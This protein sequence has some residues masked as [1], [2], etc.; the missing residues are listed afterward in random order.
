MSIFK[1]TTKKI[2]IKFIY[3][4]VNVAQ[5]TFITTYQNVKQNHEE[6]ERHEGLTELASRSIAE[7]KKEKKSK[8]ETT[9][10]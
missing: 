10:A 6:H 9:V 8:S 5:L 3:H 7:L 2:I 4:T 1:P